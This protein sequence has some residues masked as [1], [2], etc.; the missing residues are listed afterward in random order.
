MRTMLYSREFPQGKVYDTEKGMP[1]PHVS[2]APSDAVDSPAKLQLTSDQIVEAAV[3]A[4]LAKQVRE[5]PELE[6]EYEKK[7][8]RRPSNLWKDETLIKK[9]DE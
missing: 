6:A 2:T 1:D 4:E 5:R 8:G 7:F 3:K 9:L